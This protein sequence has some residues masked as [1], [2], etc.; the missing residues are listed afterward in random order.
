MGPQGKKLRFDEIS[1]SLL[2]LFSVAPHLLSLHRFEGDKFAKETVEGVHL[3]FERHFCLHAV[4]S[5]E[6]NSVLPQSD[7]FRVLG[8]ELGRNV[9]TLT[10]PVRTPPAPVTP[11]ASGR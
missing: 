6:Y 4:L 7:K 11:L 8:E 3:V 5:F 10:G 1:N 2:G 9:R